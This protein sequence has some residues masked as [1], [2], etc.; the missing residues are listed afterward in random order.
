MLTV[1]SPYAFFVVFLTGLAFGLGWSVA[2]WFVGK[3]LR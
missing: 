3:V 2:T 1:T